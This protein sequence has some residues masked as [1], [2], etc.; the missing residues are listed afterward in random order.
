[1]ISTWRINLDD[2]L[3]QRWVEGERIEYKAGWNPDG[4]FATNDNRLTFVVRLPMHPLAE[5]PVAEVA[6][7]ATPE[8]TQQVTPEVSQQ[9]TRSRQLLV[10]SVRRS[11]LMVV[12]TP[13]WG[14]GHV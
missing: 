5:L 2:L 13:G 3:N 14:L 12:M 1:M 8:V 9:V 6:E 7:Q 4:I 11:E 10:G